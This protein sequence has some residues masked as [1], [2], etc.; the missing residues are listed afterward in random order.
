MPELLD[1]FRA[2]KVSMETVDA[3]LDS[4]DPERI[5]EALVSLSLNDPDWSRVQELCLKYAASPDAG[6]RAICATCLGH[7]ARIH[8]HLDLDRVLPVLRTLIDDPLTEGYAETAFDDL[9]MFIGREE[10]EEVWLSLAAIRDRDTN[11]I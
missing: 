1:R 4:G 3:E 2:G 11:L 5:R 7:L 8:G 10:I 6:I 9:N